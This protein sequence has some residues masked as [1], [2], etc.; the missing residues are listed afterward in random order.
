MRVYILDD[1][2][3]ARG[4]VRHFIQ[5]M[6]NI[7][8]V[9]E[10]GS[11]L[12]AIAE[13]N[14]LKPD[15]LF[16]DIDMPKLTGFQ[17]LPYLTHRPLVVFLTAYDQY[18]IEAFEINALDY[19]LKPPSLERLTRSLQRAGDQWDRLEKIEFPEGKPQKL[20]NV[21]C[22][23][24]DRSVVVWL[25]DIA[26]FTKYGRYTA[27]FTWEGRELITPLTTDYLE[28]YLPESFF[29]R[30][31]RAEIIHKSSVISFKSLPNGQLTLD[32]K[33]GTPVTVSRRRVKLFKQ[34]LA[35]EESS[36]S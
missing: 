3:G 30:I 22:E 5:A 34:W 18:A 35:G 9:G 24:G 1:E 16:L 19:V 2:P 4:L 8:I 29:F 21:V 32:L 26:L 33:Q 10:N 15:L 12:K 36:A 23:L 20:T 6:D 17:V 27:L 11:P 13:I 28:E 31:N 25:K 7:D 14:E